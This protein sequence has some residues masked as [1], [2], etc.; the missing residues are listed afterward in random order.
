MH[1]DPDIVF[2]PVAPGVAKVLHRLQA[3]IFKTIGDARPPVPAGAI[4]LNP[5]ARLNFSYRETKHGRYLTVFDR[6]AGFEAEYCSPFVKPDWGWEHNHQPGLW[7]ATEQRY[8]AGTFRTW[9][10][11][12]GQF[13]MDDFGDL[14]QVS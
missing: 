13:T 12:I 14:V 7:Q 11:S 6:E 10:A 5:P 8:E 9:R 3:E 4:L 1:R 2:A